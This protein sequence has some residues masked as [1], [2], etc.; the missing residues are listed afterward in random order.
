M[1][2]LTTQ[3]LV[4]GFPER[5]LAKHLVK[6][7]LN[8][9]QQTVH[10]IVTSSQM[11]NAEDFIQQLPHA[12]QQRIQLWTGDPRGID[13]GL[14]GKESNQISDIIEVVHHCCTITDPAGTPEEAKGNVCS[15][16]EVF[17]LIDVCQHFKRL[18]CWSSTT[19]SG[20][21]EGF[22]KEGDLTDRHGFRNVIEQS[23]FQVEQMVREAGATYPTVILRPA[24]LIGYSPDKLTKEPQGPYL[25]LRFLLSTPEDFQIPAP[26]RGSVRISM[27]PVDYAAQAGLHIASDRRSDGHTFHIVNPKPVTV[28]YAFELFTQAAG[29]P[30]PKEYSPLNLATALMRAPGM[31]R[32]THTTRAFLEQMRTDVIYDDTHTRELLL[33]SAITCPPLE[34]YIDLMVQQARQVMS[35]DSQAPRPT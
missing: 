26:S 14:S 19:V 8:S 31:Q 30:A 13:M 4:T 10:C 5:Q 1:T 34:H 23:L 12:A 24:L 2:T 7:L 27:V 18:I 29:R 16:A 3:T 17:E 32:L 25:L 6:E 20:K 33:S 11:S 9:Q 21:R 28:Q 22:V 35:E 15:T